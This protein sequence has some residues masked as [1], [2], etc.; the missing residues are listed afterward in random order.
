[1]V[2]HTGEFLR[3]DKKL[4]AFWSFGMEGLV[5]GKMLLLQCEDLIA[6]DVRK[7]YIYYS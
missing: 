6:L 5:D 3:D 4:M 7:G 1:M 2:L